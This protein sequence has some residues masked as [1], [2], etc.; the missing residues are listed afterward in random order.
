MTFKPHHLL[1]APAFH[2]PHI[3]L[4]E[5]CNLSTIRCSVIV[6]DPFHVWSQDIALES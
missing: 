3:A 4:W 5:L 1:L 6:L 2:S